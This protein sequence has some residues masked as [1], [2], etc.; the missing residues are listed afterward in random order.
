MKKSIS[1]LLLLLGIL[2][3]VSSMVM[4]GANPGTGIKSTSH[5]LSSA[6]GRGGAWGAGTAADPTLDRICI[7]CHAPH[8]TI[9]MAQASSAGLT[10]FPLW[11]HDLTTI[12]SYTPYTDNDGT[13]IPNNISHQLNAAPLTTTPGSISK[14]CLSCHDGSVAVSSYGNFGNAGSHYNTGSI[15]TTGTRFAIGEGG[16][17]SNH[18]PI[19]FDYDTVA[20]IDDEIRDSGNDLLGNNPYGLTINDLLYGG[21]MECASC[22]DVHN[23]KNTGTKF[24]WVADTN[25]NLCLSCHAK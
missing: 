2:L 21:K 19:G 15:T 24:T 3:L 6:T 12:P 4:A 7:Y 23:T 25:S 10:Y 11:N 5:D 1:I 13:D 17:L 14:L 20:A 16:D 18:H 8:H 9:T 22:H